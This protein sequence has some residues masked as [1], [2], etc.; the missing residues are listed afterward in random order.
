MLKAAA[1]MLGLPVASLR[2]WQQ[3]RTM[4]D[5]AAKTLIRLLYGHPEDIRAWLV[6]A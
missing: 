1:E 3:R 5:D 4:P 2:N 6:A